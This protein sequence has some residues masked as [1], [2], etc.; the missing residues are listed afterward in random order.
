M[1]TPNKLSLLR[2]IMVPLMM[3]AFMI[4]FP[5]HMFVALGIFI[6]A[7]FTDFLDG[8]L[9]RKYNQI[10]NLGKFLDSI[11]DKMLTTTA[12]ILLACYNIIPQPYGVICLT[13]FVLRDIII[14]FVRQM[15]ATKGV[16]LAANKL[17]KYKTFAVDVGIPVLMLA[18][19]LANLSVSATAVNV[20]LWIG[21]GLI[22]LASLLNLVSGTVYLV[23]NRSA[24][25]DT[26]TKEE[27]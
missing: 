22:I 10:T 15:A 9:A 19:A 8:H 20:V 25:T 12:L 24:F 16:V 18:V 3:V 6:L 14:N 11:A 4:E 2:I 7:A 26:P 21:Y 5:Y 13:L 23:Q 17:G 1:N 27:K